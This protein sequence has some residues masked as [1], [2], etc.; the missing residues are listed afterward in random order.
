MSDILSAIQDDI[1]EYENLCRR[2]N[3][4]VQT[5]LTAFGDRSPDCYGEHAQELKQRLIEETATKAQAEQVSDEASPY[6]TFTVRLEK[7]LQMR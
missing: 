3:E 1:N 2:Y 6:S 5:K 4:Q 7:E